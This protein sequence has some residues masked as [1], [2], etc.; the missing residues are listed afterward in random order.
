MAPWFEIRIPATDANR[1]ALL[2]FLFDMGCAGCQQLEQEVLSYFSP[3]FSEP[4]L[5]GKT[6]AYLRALQE[7]GL[8]TPDQTYTLTLTPSEDWNAEWKKQIKPCR[9]SKRFIV[10]PTWEPLHE[11]ADTFVIEIDPKQAF[12]TGTHETTRLMLHLLEDQVMGDKE[13]LDVGTGTGILAIAAMKLG[14]RHVIAL[15]HDPVAIEAAR[16]N[17]KRN[18]GAPKVE[19]LVGELD[20]VALP[21]ASLDLILANLTKR[22]FFPLLEN[23]KGL[24]APA[25][26]LLMS[27][28]LAEEMPEIRRLIADL[29]ALSISDVRTMSEWAALVVKRAQGQSPTFVSTSTLRFFL[30]RNR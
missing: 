4:M 29:G 3:D 20:S 25:G 16:E 14:A 26:Q 24:L 17:V 9:V 12:G 10:K 11:P 15:D 8:T 6:E 5:R 30:S 18:L 23:L 7:I 19:L 1:E 27:G 28:I 21:A 13:V 22:T 2:N